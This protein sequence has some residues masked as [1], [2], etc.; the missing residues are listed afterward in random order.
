MAECPLRTDFTRQSKN[1]NP[2][3][4]KMNVRG[5]MSGLFDGRA[6]NE[7]SPAARLKGV[8]AR[9]RAW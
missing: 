9:R 5:E 1:L 4:E 8:E 2:Q 7:K 3:S 6:Q